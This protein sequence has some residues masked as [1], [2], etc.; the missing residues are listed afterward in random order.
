MFLPY[1]TKA[2]QYDYSASSSFLLPPATGVQRFICMWP[3]SF[4]TIEFFLSV[5]VM[6]VLKLFEL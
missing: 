3:Y 5:Q 1:Y 2:F 6:L 4:F